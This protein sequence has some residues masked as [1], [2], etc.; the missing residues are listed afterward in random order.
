MPLTLRIEHSSHCWGRRSI[1]LHN[2]TATCEWF[3]G[4]ADYCAYWRPR[5]VGG[6]VCL[7]FSDQTDNYQ[8]HQWYT[9]GAGM[10][11]Q[12]DDFRWNIEKSIAGI[13]NLCKHSAWIKW[14]GI[15][16]TPFPRLWSSACPRYL[17]S[18]A[19][20]NDSRTHRNTDRMLNNETMF[21]VSMLS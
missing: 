5:G 20:S 2:A 3:A 18:R 7:A 17:C 1:C 8:V 14:S 4:V 10:A 11:C 6:V 16:F 12:A 13:M 19:G 15:V 9:L 21:A